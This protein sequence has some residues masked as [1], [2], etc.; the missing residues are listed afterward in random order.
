MTEKVLNLGADR[1]QEPAF[2]GKTTDPV[3]L[4][5]PYSSPADFSA[6]YPQ[7]L[8]TTEILAMCEEVT[9]LSAI[10]EQGTSLKAEYWREMT[11]LAFT[12]GSAYLAFPDGACPEEY[13]HNGSNTSVDIKNIGAKKSL[14]QR[15]IMHSQAIASAN[16]NGIN[17]LV[18]PNPGPMLPGASGNNTFQA[19]VVAN[20]KE[21]E[22]LLATVLVLNGEDDLLVTG[23]H[24]SNSLE[25]TGIENWQANYS[26]HFHTGT[27]GT[28]TFSAS[29]FDRWLAE[30]CASPTVLMGH[31]AAIQELLS[32]YFQLGFQGSQ[33][34]SFSSGGRVTPGFNFASYVNTGIGTLPVVADKNFTRVDNSD[35]TFGASIW[36]MRMA[37]NGEP[38]V[39]RATQVP[40]AMTDLVPGCT[41]ISFEIW[42]ATALV[43][44]HACAHGQY[45]GRFAGNVVVTCPAVG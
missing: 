26:V 33:S 7:P 9:M 31:P 8:D 36:A 15:D 30:G 12:S 17:R 3:I 22:A 19:E 45:H 23:N 21:K 20:V 27:S 6:Q 5:Q 34:I 1:G 29:T 40:L 43:I 24:V 2:V 11:S 10:P 39:Y 18:G 32:S 14:T 4:P 38:L 44:K 41:A 25:F 37:H 13:S 28:G 35:G 16:W 42:K